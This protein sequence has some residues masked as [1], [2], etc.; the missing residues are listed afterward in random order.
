[1]QEQFVL[2]TVISIMGYGEKA[3]QEE[4]RSRFLVR[5]RKSYSKKSDTL[6]WALLVWSV[7]AVAA[8]LFTR[9]ATAIAIGIVV[10]SGYAA[11][12]HMKSV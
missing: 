1:M 9:S 12:H 3:M 5:V 7:S 6:T 10:S 4:Y 11:V 8:A 2:S